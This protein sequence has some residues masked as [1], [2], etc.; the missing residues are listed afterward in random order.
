MEVLHQ[1]KTCFSFGTAVY[2]FFVD[3]TTAV[4]ALL[5]LDRIGQASLRELLRRFPSPQEALEH[6]S[7]A[8]RL[9]RAK[10]LEAG[11]VA[12]TLRAEKV[13]LLRETASD[14]PTKLADLPDCPEFVF[15]QGNFT[16]LSAP[17]VG[18]VGSTRPSL[19]ASQLS[20]EFGKE[21][22]RRGICVVSG[23]ARGIDFFAHKGAF[24]AG[25]TS[26][27]VL[28]CG[29]LRFCRRVGY[30]DR[31]MLLRNALLLSEL[32]PLQEWATWCAL[33]RNRLISALS[34]LV[35]SFQDNLGR[36][37]QKTLEIARSIHRKTAVLTT[38][39]FTILDLL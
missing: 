6:F 1:R 19:R 39:D 18:I 8:R 14:F 2:R 21:C 28:P 33:A 24:D 30:P 26:V 35:I 32:H 3:E 7:S 27:L 17:A 34:D 9:D 4:I 15:A 23:N 22:A 12:R 20:Y 37:A 38:R 36:G 11:K 13:R 10:V 5:S 29:I 31:A 25:G 16:L